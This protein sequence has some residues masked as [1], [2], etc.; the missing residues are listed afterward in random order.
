M[1]TQERRRRQGQAG[2]RSSSALH[3]QLVGLAA[4]SPPGLPHL[5]PPVPG[6]MDT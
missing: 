4:G 5:P 2:S 3:T 6:M 1:N